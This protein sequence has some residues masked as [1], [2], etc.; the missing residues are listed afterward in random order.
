MLDLAHHSLHKAHDNTPLDLNSLQR[1]GLVDNEDGA[2]IFSGPCNPLPAKELRKKLKR[3]RLEEL[4]LVD[5]SANQSTPTYTS[6]E[7]MQ[8][9]EE[10][11][12]AQVKMQ[13]DLN[14]FFE[15]HNFH[16]PSTS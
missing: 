9:L 7:L 2:Y 15:F 14:A 13:S 16:P 8:K 5:R 1:M 4:D 3:A 6:Y 11:S 10:I 12:R